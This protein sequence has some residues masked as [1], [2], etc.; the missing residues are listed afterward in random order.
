MAALHG[1][2]QLAAVLLLALASAI[3]AAPVNITVDAPLGSNSVT[4]SWPEGGVN[5]TAT[6]VC[7]NLNNASASVS[8][9]L[10]GWYPAPARTCVWTP[11]GTKCLTSQRLSLLSSRATWGSR[12]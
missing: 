4:L 12:D 6:V 10:D 7:F 11:A 3:Q 9:R 5:S 2:L 8:A 1:R